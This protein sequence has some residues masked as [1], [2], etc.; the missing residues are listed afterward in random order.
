MGSSVTVL[1]RCVVAMVRNRDKLLCE[2]AVCS[3]AFPFSSLESPCSSSDSEI[4]PRYLL[5][6]SHFCTEGV[7]SNDLLRNWGKNVPK[8]CLNAKFLA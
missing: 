1:A 4:F 3:V 8:S 2:K 6:I 5:W 7:A